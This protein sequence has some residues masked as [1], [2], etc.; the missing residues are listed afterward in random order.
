[1][2]DPILCTTIARNV[3]DIIPIQMQPKKIGLS[4]GAFRQRPT[5]HRLI[6]LI[7]HQRLPVH[8]GILTLIHV[9]DF[10]AEYSVREIGQ[11]DPIAH[12]IIAPIL[13]ELYM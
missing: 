6:R 5:I 4:G 12:S 1:V 8:T 11:G 7:A 10:L 3:P 2:A 13:L 9:F